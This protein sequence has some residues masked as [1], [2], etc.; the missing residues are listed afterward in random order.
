MNAYIKKLGVKN[1]DYEYVE[2]IGFDEELLAFVPQPATAVLL[3]F[4]ITEEVIREMIHS[5]DNFSFS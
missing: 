1:D 3:I 4:P 5:F 2:V